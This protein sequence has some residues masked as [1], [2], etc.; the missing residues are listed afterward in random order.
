MMTSCEEVR[1]L[2]ADYVSAR[3]APEQSRL[4][5]QHRQTCPDCGEMVADLETLKEQIKAGG[6]AIFEPHPEPASLHRY[7]RGE[8]G[9]EAERIRRHLEACATCQLE[10]DASKR[11]ARARAPAPISGARPSLPWMSLAAGVGALLGL[12]VGWRV[13][14]TPQP[15]EPRVPAPPASPPAGPAVLEAPVIHL[16]PGVLR[17]GEVPLQRWSLSRG[18]PFLNVAVPIAVPADF[19]ESESLRFELRGPAGEVVWQTEMPVSRVREHLE[20]AEVVSLAV[21]PARELQPG[22]YH[23]RVV[24]SGSLEAPPLYKADI[25]IDYRQSPAAT[26][27]PQ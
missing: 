25:E 7:A 8:S 2:L 23:L 11:I 20:S 16:L 1:A 9:K 4:V 3:L 26:K 17:G 27:A 22:Q 10:V 24:R 12:L 21:W 5:E 6:E 18:E 14:S 13:L 19:P 15:V